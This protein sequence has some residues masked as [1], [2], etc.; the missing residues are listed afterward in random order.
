MLGYLWRHFGAKRTY[1]IHTMPQKSSLLNRV[2]VVGSLAR[3]DSIPKLSALADA[4]ACDLVE[5]RLDHYPQQVD[6]LLAILPSLKVPILLTARHASEGGKNNLSSRDRADLL[7]KLLPHASVVDIELRTLGE[8]SGLVREIRAASALIIASFHDFD[9][10]PGASRL[11]ELVAQAKAHGADACKIAVTPRTPGDLANI[12][13]LFSP[14]PLHPLSAMG[15]GKYGR[16]SRLLFASLGS[17]FN[18]GYLDEPTVPGQWEARRLRELI[19]E[20]REEQ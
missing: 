20:V 2:S 16:I 7:R 12:T 10:T 4:E 14:S 13:H 17:I 6:N 5:L 8:M 19:R 15:M 9:R 3:A 18:Y 11:Q 1:R